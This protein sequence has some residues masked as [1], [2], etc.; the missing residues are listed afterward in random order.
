MCKDFTTR[1]A[2]DTEAQRIQMWG[3]LKEFV[4]REEFLKPL[5]FAPG[6]APKNRCGIFNSGTP[7]L[8]MPQHSLLWS[9]LLCASV[10]LAKRVVTLLVIWSGCFLTVANWIEPWGQIGQAGRL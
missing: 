5:L 6:I 10:S 3:F 4:E 9:S 2:R 8:Q 7:E 1:F